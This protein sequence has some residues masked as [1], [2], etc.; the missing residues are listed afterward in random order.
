MKDENFYSHRNHL[1]LL[2]DRLLST[3]VVGHPALLDSTELL[4]GEIF[5]D[6]LTHVRL[7][8]FIDA[9][10]LLVSHQVGTCQ[11]FIKGFLVVKRGWVL[12]IALELAVLRRLQLQVT[13]NLVL[14]HHLRACSSRGNNLAAE[15]E[16][17]RRHVR[18]ED[19]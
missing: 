19:T 6:L 13:I 16:L 4:L 3:W 14:G 5:D 8:A 10:I 18:R 2:H 9:A 17:A 12:G 7:T 11:H 15:V 1:R